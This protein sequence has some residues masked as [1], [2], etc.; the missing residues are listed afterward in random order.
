MTTYTDNFYKNLKE[1]SPES[2]REDWEYCG[3]NT[4]NRLEYFKQLYP[5]KKIQNYTDICICGKYPI[6]ENCYIRTVKDKNIIVVVGNH[7]IKKYI[8]EENQ[9]KR[10]LECSK[11]HNN[12]KDSYC[13]DCRGGTIRFGEYKNKSYIWVFR[14]NIDY[15][16]E[17]YNKY[18]IYNINNSF[19]DGTA[20]HFIQWLK[21]EHQVNDN[22]F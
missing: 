10:C 8:N 20:R 16:K 7:C 14:E 3:G 12:R 11:P 21:I 18:R 17:L 22:F 5:S 4:G 1:K 15:V 6:K 13:N 19:D 2:N 9:K